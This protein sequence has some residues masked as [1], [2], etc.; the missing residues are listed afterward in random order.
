MNEQ[1]SAELSYGADHA[2]FREKVECKVKRLWWQEKGLSYTASGYGRKIPTEYMV[3]V[4]NRWRRVYCCIMSNNGTLYI[5]GARGW[6][7]VDI[8]RVEA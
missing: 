7:T 1:Y 4:N 6:I 3:K 8:E 5:D 2:F